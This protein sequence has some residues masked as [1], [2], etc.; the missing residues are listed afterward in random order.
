[1]DHHAWSPGNLFQM[2]LL[3]LFSFWVFCYLLLINIL[4]LKGF[5][6][7][8][9][10]HLFISCSLSDPMKILIDTM[11]EVTTQTLRVDETTRDI[12]TSPLLAGENP[13]AEDE[14][15]QHQWAEGFLKWDLNGS[16][17]L[18]TGGLTVRIP[19]NPTL[20]KWTNIIAIAGSL[21]CGWTVLLSIAHPL[22]AL[23]TYTRVKGVHLFTAILQVTGH[24]PQDIFVATQLTGDQ[25][26]RLPIEDLLG[27]PEDSQFFLLEILIQ[28]K[29]PMNSQVMAWSVGMNLDRSLICTMESIGPLGHRGAPERCQGEAHVQRGTS[30]KHHPK[31]GKIMSGGGL[32]L[33]TSP[34]HRS[35]NDELC[36]APDCIN[37]MGLNWVWCKWDLRGALLL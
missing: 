26:L 37:Y 31:L 27:D 9:E 34:S 16:H 2:M 1:M 8:V 32:R 11:K 6:V 33:A 17:D 28:E 21:H 10:N 36:P 35:C 12:I 25:D 5:K 14:A 30:T 19:S 20:I 4:K 29:E 3:F 18:V 22:T 23:H 13:E 15:D 7:L 24:L